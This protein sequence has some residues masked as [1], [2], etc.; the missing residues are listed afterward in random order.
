MKLRI[1]IAALLIAG[2]AAFAFIGTASA[3]SC[4]SIGLNG[5]ENQMT[6]CT[7]AVTVDAA[8]PLGGSVSIAAEPTDTLLPNAPGVNFLGDAVTVSVMNASEVPQSTALLEICFN[9]PSASGNVYSWSG[10]AWVRL[11][12]FYLPGMDCA[13][14][15]TV[16]TFTRN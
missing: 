7:S 2:L 1:T 12:T 16:G 5:S 8:V 11:P 15:W 3:N 4:A 9:D 14:S 10:S 13:N 6:A